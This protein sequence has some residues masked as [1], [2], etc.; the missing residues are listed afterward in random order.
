MATP[1]MV[2][3]HWR[4]GTAKVTPARKLS[5]SLI[6]ALKSS[7]ALMFLTIKYFRI[8]VLADL[9]NI[10]KDNSIFAVLQPER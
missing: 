3:T 8:F 7:K 10:D 6:F 9:T 5:E 2:P 1:H 4:L